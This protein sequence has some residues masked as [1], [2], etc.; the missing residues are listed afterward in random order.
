MYTYTYIWWMIIDGTPNILTNPRLWLEDA[1]T[2][3]TIASSVLAGRKRQLREMEASE[4]GRFSRNSLVWFH[5]SLSIN[6]KIDKNLMGYLLR[7]RT[8]NIIYRCVYGNGLS[9]AFMA[10]SKGDWWFKAAAAAFLIGK[11][12]FGRSAVQ[13]VDWV[14]PR[15]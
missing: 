4:V 7:S 9:L 15:P 10:I 5:E 12:G 11:S 13:L 6:K 1:R 14:S 3:S 8:D 2:V